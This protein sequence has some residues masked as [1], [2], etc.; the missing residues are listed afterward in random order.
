MT[1]DLSN[2]NTNVD[3]LDRED[4]DFYSNLMEHFELMLLDFKTLDLIDEL[5]PDGEGGQSK[6]ELGREK[7]RQFEGS[8]AIFKALI[9]SRI[10][11]QRAEETKVVVDR[12]FDDIYNNVS[13]TLENNMIKHVDEDRNQLNYIYEHHSKSLIEDTEKLL[14]T[15]PVYLRNAK[16]ENFHLEHQISALLNGRGGSGRGPETPHTDL[17]LNLRREIQDIRLF[18]YDSIIN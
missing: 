2:L 16:Q 1:I 13:K 6:A 4:R 5:L 14:N 8:T 11:E 18:H 12:K 10:K 9:E 17:A 15:I 3:N 7:A